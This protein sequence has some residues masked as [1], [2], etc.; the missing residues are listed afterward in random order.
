MDVLAVNDGPATIILETAVLED[1]EG[2]NGYEE[3]EPSE[4]FDDL[5]DKL[6]VDISI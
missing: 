1:E 3:E 6:G 4:S 2:G 5:L